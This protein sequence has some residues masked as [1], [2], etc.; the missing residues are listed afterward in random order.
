MNVQKPSPQKNAKNGKGSAR[1]CQVLG[2]IIHA[3]FVA[4][5]FLSIGRQLFEKNRNLEDET[6]L[7]EG[8]VSV[9][10]S[11]Y[12]RTHQDDDQDE[13]DHVTFSDSD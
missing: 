8:T 4:H 5:C 2:T 12:D 7:E 11:Q 3:L 13:D 1:V 10:I 9:D 6:L